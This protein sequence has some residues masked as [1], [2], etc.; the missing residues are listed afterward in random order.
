MRHRFNFAFLAL[1]PYRM[2][3]INSEHPTA[4]YPGPSADKDDSAGTGA[5]AVSTSSGSMSKTSQGCVELAV[6]QCQ[7]IIN[8]LAKNALFGSSSV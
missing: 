1:Q 7:G 6:E 4:R 2:C 3:V 8:Q 5:G